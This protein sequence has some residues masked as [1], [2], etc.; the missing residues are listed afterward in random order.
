M[1]AGNSSNGAPVRVACLFRNSD[2]RQQNSIDRQKREVAP[3]VRRKGYEVVSEF[4]F[5]DIAGDKVKSHADWK[6]LLQE[7]GRR[8]GVLVVDEPS[9]LSRDDPD[10]W[11]A[12][13]KLP[14]KRA[15]VRVDSVTKGLSEW[16]SIAGD[17]IA[18]VNAHKA[19]EEVRDLSRR[20]LG[21]MA[22][23]ARAGNWFGWMPPYG[24][25]VRREVDP[26]SGKVIDREVIYGPEEEVRVVRFIFDC[27]ANRGWSVRRVCR[28][29]EARGVKPPP[30]NGYGKNKAR[31]SWNEGTVRKI[32]RRRKYL[33]DLPWNE[34][35]QG[36]YSFLSGGAVAQ[37]PGTNRTA[38]RNPAAE[39]IVVEGHPRVPPIID[40]ETFARAQAALA[41]LKKRAGNP[42]PDNNRYLF[43]GLLVCG[44]CG[45]PMRGQP[46]HGHKAY[47]CANYKEYGREACSR[48]CV[49][50]ADVWE[51]VLGALRD[52]VLSP[53]RLDAVEAE[54]RRQLEADRAGGEA[55][56]LRAQLAGLAKDIDQGNA[57]LARLPADVL[58][59]VV[60]K[61]REWE[62]ERARVAARLAELDG[63][64]S[65][66]LKA[67]DEARK[68]LWRLR[69]GLEGDDLEAQA[70]VAREV[71]EKVEVRFVPHTTH[72][73]RS[74]AGKGRTLH[75]PESLL[76]DVKDDLGL[77][78]LRT[79][80]CRSPARGGG[81][82]RASS[83][84]P[85][86]GRP[87]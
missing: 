33:G 55:D 47:L 79:C 77:S 11:V 56:R 64:D 45:R 7:A 21:G 22:G 86:C 48:N 53:P 18:L 66:A 74:K 2:A 13:V 44:D 26:L 68:G 15:G 8:W 54:V 38:S 24:L 43:T 59:G 83:C 73:R 35:H 28:E 27:V 1:P 9:R 3:Y 41:G 42:A 57:N 25:R 40:R 75:L 39:V 58:A 46:D 34:T 19:R 81:P 31:G 84:P 71:L 10:E 14:L 4:T 80:C 23:R 60:A 76:L 67:L 65:A 49:R 5:D 32:L 36:K 69:E 87:G 29:L 37:H 17:I 85:A 16:D 63:G 72:G 70:V 61:V 52:D 30:G 50:E 82:G 20:T 62:G 6:R 78:H 12:E 51:A